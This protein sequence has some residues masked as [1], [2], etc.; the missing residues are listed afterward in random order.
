MKKRFE[1]EFP[2]A[3]ILGIDEK[4][5]FWLMIAMGENYLSVYCGNF[6]AD[7]A[8]FLELPEFW[9][10]FKQIVTQADQGRFQSSQLAYIEACSKLDDVEGFYYNMILSHDSLL[11]TPNRVVETAYKQRFKLL[12]KTQLTQTI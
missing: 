5:H 2:F 7:I 10:W 4:Q 6:P 1:H 8:I 9:Q 3:A 12:E 11:M